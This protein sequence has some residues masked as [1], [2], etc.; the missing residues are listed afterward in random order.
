MLLLRTLSVL[1]RCYV[2]RLKTKMQFMLV[3]LVHRNVKWKFFQKSLRWS[4]NY[5]SC[6]FRNKRLSA[7]LAQCRFTVML[8]EFTL[9]FILIE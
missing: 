8:V 2:N 4:K 7:E 5:I 6:S 1:Q 3:L 9:I